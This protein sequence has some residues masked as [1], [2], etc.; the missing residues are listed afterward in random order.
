MNRPYRN[1][2][3]I[4]SASCALRGLRLAL[5]TQPNL[6][7]LL[8]GAWTVMLVGIWSGLPLAHMAVLGAVLALPLG[9]EL[10]NTSVEQSIDLVVKEYHP[11]ARAAKD[12]AAAGV[13][14]SLLVA[15]GTSTALLWPPWQWPGIIGSAL[16]SSPLRAGMLMLVGV[17]LMGTH[18]VILRRGGG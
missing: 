5:L 18:L 11:Q 15:A 13:L 8:G 16:G 7:L 2:T 17:A 14:V 10:L 9:A 3:I 4:E 12:I 1:A 6:W